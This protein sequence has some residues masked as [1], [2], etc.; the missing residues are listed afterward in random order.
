MWPIKNKK[1]YTTAQEI[2]QSM[3]KELKSLFMVKVENAIHKNH[4]INDLSKLIGVST[5]KNYSVYKDIT[6][7]ANASMPFFHLK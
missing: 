6:M 4:P 5:Q 2:F 1:N 7:P 3:Q